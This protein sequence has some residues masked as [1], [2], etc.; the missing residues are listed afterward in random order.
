MEEHQ[1][2]E[3]FMTA[4]PDVQIR[5][6]KATDDPDEIY[7]VFRQD[8]VVI[9]EDFLSADTIAKINAEIDP[10]V[11]RADPLMR[12]VY[13]FDLG[14]DAPGVMDQSEDDPAEESFLTGNTR[15]ITGLSTKSPTFVTDVLLHPLY[16]A[17][18]DRHLLPHC[19][20]YVL[21]HSHLI[22]VGAGAK[23]QP[24]HRDSFNWVNLPGLGPDS[25]IQFASIV[26]LVDFTED[27]G[28]TKAVPGSHRWESKTFL[29][30][31]ATDRMP[32]PED[33]L[34]AVMPAGSVVLYTGW[35]LHGAGK[36]IT[37]DQWRRGLHV[38]FCQGWLRTEENNTLATPP[39]VARHL[40]LRA[41]QL[42]G[43]DVHTA[44]GMLELRSP[45]KKMQDG[46][47]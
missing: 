30:D 2:R 9:V 34:Q 23:G 42:L 11:E 28:A 36:N 10:F 12:D 41:Q 19:F 38:S 4:K 37:T 13:D 33:I 15:N 43:Y 22:N 35:T 8:G 6:M 31:P 16:A 46:T 7:A 18:C 17:L 3:L 5:H 14:M 20:D 45:I 1:L 32:E 44:L 26:A 24:I 40:P 39:D 25:D 47:L 29:P 27:N 21:N